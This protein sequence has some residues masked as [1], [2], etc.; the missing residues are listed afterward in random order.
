MT[1]KYFSAW[2]INTKGSDVA[3][4]KALTDNQI[5]ASWGVYR[6]P[7]GDVVVAE[8]IAELDEEYAEYVEC[9]TVEDYI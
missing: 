4:Q 2:T 3:F 1:Q 5:D 9:G 6:G 7:S 8:N